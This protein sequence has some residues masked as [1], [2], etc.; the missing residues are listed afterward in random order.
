M[1]ERVVF[2]TVGTTKFE[3]LIRSIDSD[4]V[5]KAL[6]NRGY[7]HVVVQIGQ[8]DYVPFERKGSDCIKD[9]YGLTVEWYRL[10]PAILADLKRASLVISHAGYGSLMESLSL[11]KPVVAVINDKLMDNHQVDIAQEL[12]RQRCAVACSPQTLASTLAE[13]DFASFE[14]LPLAQPSRIVSHIDSLMSQ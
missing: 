11:G 2:V 7:T 4:E 8:G 13:V 12:Q 10:K 9:E 6:R 3:E 1:D 5:L 14:R